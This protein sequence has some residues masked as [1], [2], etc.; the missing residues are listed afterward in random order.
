MSGRALVS[1]LLG[2]ALIFGAVLW[3]FQNYAYYYPVT[4]QTTASASAAAPASTDVNAPATVSIRLT[5]L[6]GG[7]PVVIPVTDFQGMDAD[8]S[9]LKFRACFVVKTPLAKMVKTYKTYDGAT[10]L[11]APGWFDC[12][13]AGQL[14]DDIKAG[15]AIA[16][17]GQE[18]VYYGVDRVVA[19][20]PD[21]RAYAWNQINRCG[22]A[23]FNNGAL[24]ADCPKIP[25]G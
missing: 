3:Y 16:F 19:I 20:Y 13:D 11:I 24:P 10:P 12:F 21:G 23:G 18:N 7:Q 6:T 4:L 22:Q 14:T 9:P 2:F 15:V 5:R 17:M 25:E 1:S 8:T